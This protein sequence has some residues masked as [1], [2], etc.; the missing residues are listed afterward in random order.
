MFCSTIPLN[1]KVSWR[2]K[3]QANICIAKELEDIF[4]GT[5]ADY[6]KRLNCRL[7]MKIQADNAYYYENFAKAA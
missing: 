3:A 2:K 7:R 6:L 4:G 1:S 5:K